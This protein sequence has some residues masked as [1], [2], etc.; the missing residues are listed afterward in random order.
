[1]PRAAAEPERHRHLE[2][3][4]H[5]MGL[6][7][8]VGIDGGNEGAELRRDRHE[9]M[10]GE[11][12]DGFAHRCPADLELLGSRL[13]RKRVTGLQLEPH[14]HAAEGLVDLIGN[15]TPAVEIRSRLHLL[16]LA[17]GRAC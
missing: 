8:L 17:D 15:R 7:N 9:T 1:M 6:A 16:D 11:P 5:E 2:V 12:Q 14:D 4:A 3:R 10:L 13:F